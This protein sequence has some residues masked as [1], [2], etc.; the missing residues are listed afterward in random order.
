MKRRD[1]LTKASITAAYGIL[2]TQMASN[3]SLA[4]A[5][6]QDSAQVPEIVW[7]D[8]QKIMGYSDKELN[9]FKNQPRTK[10]IVSRLGSMSKLTVIFEVKQSHGCLVGH[11]SGDFYVFPGGGPMDMK[12]GSQRLCPFLMPPMTRIM[13]I[14]Q[15]RLWEGLDPLPLY[16]TGHCDDVGLDCNGWGR[17]VIEAR[18]EKPSELQSS[19]K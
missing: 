10:K 12:I 3:S 6:N 16:A 4:V 14:L 5:E 11:K 17:V 2:A 15:E 13:W 7:K 9:I 1:F 8:I 19:V 18:I